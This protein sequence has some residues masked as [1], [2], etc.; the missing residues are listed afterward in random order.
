MKE[1]PLHIVQGGIDNGDKDAIER[2]SRDK[3]DLKNWVVPKHAVPGD[4]VV[5]Y[6]AGYGFFA[7]GSIKSQTKPRKNWKSR[8][9]A[10]IGSLRTISP[11]ISLVNILKFVPELTWAKYPRSITSPRPEVAHTVRNLIARRRKGNIFDLREESLSHSNLDELRRIALMR[12]RRSISKRERKVLHYARASAIKLYVLRR[13]GGICE[14][15]KEPAPFNT[16]AGTPFLEPHHLTRL[17]D[18]GPDHPKH[19]IAL[20]PNCH[21]RAHYSE[22]SISFNKSLVRILSAIE[23]KNG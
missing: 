11:P 9:G 5:V 13:A 1:K 23:K 4:D 16:P 2:A 22:D 19:V 7:T 15:C 8:Y 10:D 18:G 14:G 6:I 3:Q 12:A 20:C 21:R 17:A